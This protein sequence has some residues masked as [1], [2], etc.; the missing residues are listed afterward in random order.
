MLAFDLGV[1]LEAAALATREA[2]SM[3][4]WCSDFA[5]VLRIG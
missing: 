1:D 5:D 3:L 2:R 4:V